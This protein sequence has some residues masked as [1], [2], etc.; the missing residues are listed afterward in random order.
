MKLMKTFEQYTNSL[1]EA[2]EKKDQDSLIKYLK[3]LKT[4]PREDTVFKVDG[5][6]IPK[7]E[8]D[9]LIGKEGITYGDDKDD[10]DDES[11]DQ[12]ID[13]FL[14][15]QSDDALYAFGE[16]AYGMSDD[17]DLAD[18]WNNAKDDLSTAELIDYAKD[19]AKRFGLD[20]EELK[21]AMSGY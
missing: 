11:D 2:V 20:F 10:N 16:D 15:K 21:D 5:K 7:S 17:E 19:H 9:K 4:K 12:K 18:E 6:V 1:K 8:I 14:D 13:S 3:D